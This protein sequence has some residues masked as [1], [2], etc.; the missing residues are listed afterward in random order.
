[1]SQPTKPP[2]RPSRPPKIRL[3][4]MLVQ[5]VFI[6]DHGTYVEELEHQPVTITARDWPAYS[7]ETFPRE[8]MQLERD[9]AKRERE[10]T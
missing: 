8:L 2:K 5:P 10:S 7:A 9:L 1:M 4:K 3:V 6:I